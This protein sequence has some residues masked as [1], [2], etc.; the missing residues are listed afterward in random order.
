MTLNIQ[1]LKVILVRIQSPLK[2]G[3]FAAVLVAAGSLFLPNDY[4]STARIL[5][6]DAR[7]GGGIGQ[8]A[9]AAAAA[10]GVSIPGQ[11]S[12]DVAYVDILNSRWLRESLLQ[13]TF[14]F[15]E[16]GWYFGAVS[17]RTMTLLAYLQAKNL[18][19]GILALRSHI[20]I[21]RDL[22]T[23]LLSISVETTS[24]ELSRE[25]TRK[26]V[27]LLEEFV[28]RKSTSR[29]GAKAV[30]AEKRLQEARDSMAQSE[31]EFRKFL[32]GNRNYQT[33]SDPDVRL[34]G[35]RMEGELKLRTQLV[36]TLALSREQ[37]LL[38]EKND[39][40]ILNVLDEGNLP[41]EK[42]G[43]AR[44]QLVMFA[45]IAVFIGT[46]ALSLFSRSSALL[47]NVGEPGV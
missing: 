10:V 14:T 18:D 3:C 15:Q 2:W 23:K 27:A 26:C 47:P 35:I 5:P 43:P 31:D 8:L 36:T 22:K 17:E 12:A 46:L 34:K 29:G 24:P 20:T 32:L 45:A 41:I 6:A 4:R 40:P 37:A 13:S 21:S 30:F 19:R 33:S 39:M 42:S 44:M 1:T 25:V 28:L 11:E 9:A 16:K 38:E 7:G